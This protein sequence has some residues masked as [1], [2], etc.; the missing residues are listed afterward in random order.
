M[1]FN[2]KNLGNV[3]KKMQED[4]ARIQ[5]EL[6]ETQISGADPSGKVTAKVNGHKEVLEIK[7][8]PAV[9][10]PEDVAL[11][12]DLVLYAVQDAMKKAEEHSAQKLGAI[13]AGMPNIPGLKMF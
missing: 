12:E 2:M 3:M 5:Q 8:D 9:V 10:D 13:T 11:L 1:S 4:M 7:I 6:G